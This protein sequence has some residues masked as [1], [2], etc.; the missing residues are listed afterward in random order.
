MIFDVHYLN[1]YSLVYW[2]VADS[3]FVT[4]LL[5]VRSLTYWIHVIIGYV[6]ISKGSLASILRYFPNLSWQQMCS[7]STFLIIIFLC[8][9]LLV[10]EFN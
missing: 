9:V 1:K 3:V 8:E 5:L 6:K 4:S 2:I 7:S 10:S